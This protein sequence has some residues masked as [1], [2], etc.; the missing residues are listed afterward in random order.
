MLD[1]PP[2]KLTALC[3]P[4]HPVVFNC[5]FCLARPQVHTLSIGAAKPSD[6]D[7][8]LAALDHLDRAADLLALIEPRLEAAMHDA[9]GPDFAARFAEGLPEWHAAPGYMNL[10]VILWLRNLAL[11]WG[12]TDYA[13][14][15]YNLLGNGGHW[16]PG[17]NAAHADQLDLAD[18]LRDSPFRDLIPRLLRETHELLYDAPQKRSSET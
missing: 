13:K 9:V 4:L 15:R 16:F 18:A 10:K 7:L 12:M 3:N 14:F 8:Q 2:E 17:L 6:F 11:A 1:Q 5:L